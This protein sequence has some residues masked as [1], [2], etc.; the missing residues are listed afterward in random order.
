MNEPQYEEPREDA[1]VVEVETLPMV[2]GIIG[3]LDRA[4]IDMQIATAKQ[5]ARSVD[6]AIKEAIALATSDEEIARSMFYILPRKDKDGKKIQGETIRLA[7]IMAYC[8]GNLRI[9]GGVIEILPR[10]V[11]A[12]GTCFDL[13]RNV[14]IRTRVRR[15]IVKK[16]GTRYNDDMIQQT[17]NAATSIVIRNAILRMIPKSIVRRVYVHAQRAAAGPEHTFKAKRKAALEWFETKGAKQAQMFV[18]LGVHGPDDIGASELI[19]LAGLRTAVEDGETSIAEIL[20]KEEPQS[21]GTHE[22][23]ASILAN[24]HASFRERLAAVKTAAHLKPIETELAEK[25]KLLSEEQLTE[26]DGLVSACRE[27]FA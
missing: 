11:V 1:D 13:E 2:S 7:E 26:L 12:M 25:R 15:R 18:V 14:A 23:R 20:N 24:L 19:E 5:Y 6:K 8:W 21:E 16:D 4:Q 22:L 10:E 27:A 17:G 3:E 9:D